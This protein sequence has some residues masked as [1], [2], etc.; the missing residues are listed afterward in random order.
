MRM[1]GRFEVEL[2]TALGT[3]FEVTYSLNQQPTFSQINFIISCLV[4]LASGFSSS[5][6]R[7]ERKF[8]SVNFPSEFNLDSNKPFKLQKTFKE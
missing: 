3:W 6:I 1:C 2:N 4:K 7:S 5:T 8:H